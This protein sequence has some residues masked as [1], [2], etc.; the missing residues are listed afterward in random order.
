VAS[1]VVESD[2]KATRVP[3]SLMLG[4]NE[5][6]SPCAPVSA[7]LSRVVVAFWRSRRK[8]SICWLVSAGTRLP[9]IDSK[10]T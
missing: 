3:S 8:T 4:Q 9:A 1:S 6:R 7:T 5:A 10:T 2:R